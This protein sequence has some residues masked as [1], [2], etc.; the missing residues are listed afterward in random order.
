MSVIQR[1]P[2]LLARATAAGALM[3][4]AALP[5]AVATTA[6]ASTTPPTLSSAY[7]VGGAVASQ[8][9][10][11]AT[12][13]GT[14]ITLQQSTASTAAVTLPAG[15]II[16]GASIPPGDYLTSSVVVPA[17][18][19]TPPGAPITGTL[20][21]AATVSTLESVT[22]NA[23]TL[24]IFG[25]GA[26]GTFYVAGSGFA[27]NGSTITVTTSASG[28]TLTGTE[29]SDSLASVAYTSSS[30]TTAG[31]ASLTWADG[32]GTST[33]LATAFQVNSAPVVTSMSP[34]TLLAGQQ[35][36]VTLTG[37]NFSTPN[38]LVLTSTVDG[39]TLTVGTITPVSST[40]F[41]AVV[42]ATNPVGPSTAT[43]G[44]YTATVTNTDGGTSTS[45]AV[46]T[47]TAFGFTSASPSFIPVTGT[48]ATYTVTLSGTNLGTSGALLMATGATYASGT[49]VTGAWQLVTTSVTSSAITATFVAPSTATTGL[50]SF[51]WIN[52]T[53]QIATFDGAIGVGESSTAPGNA[54]TVTAV[55]PTGTILNIGSAATLVV[56][57]TNFVPVTS[58]TTAAFKVGGTT[59]ASGL[60][61]ASFT[62]VSTTTA[63][64][65]ITTVTSSMIAGTQDL[66]VTTA[67]GSATFA[68]ALTIGGPVI[69]SASPS[70]LGIGWSGTITLTGSGFTANDTVTVTG[71]TGGTPLYVSATTLKIPVTT[72]TGT[73]TLQVVDSTT[74]T[75]TSPVFTITAGTAPTVTGVGYSTSGTSGVGQ[76]ATAV[77][78]VITGAGYL[79][80]AT[81]TFPQAGAVG[82][83]ASVTSVSSTTILANV[84][85][86]SGT[87][88]GNYQV[89]VTNTNGGYV[90]SAA[91][92]AAVDLIVVAGPGTM[93]A[94]PSTSVPQ[95]A[96][97]NL[98]LSPGAAGQFET[99]A[100]ATSSNVLLTVGTLVL[101]ADGTLTVPV[102]TAAMTG[103]YTIGVTLTVANP[104]G[105]TSSINLSISPAPTVTGT[106]Y[107]PTFSSNVQMAITGTGFQTGMTATS[108][109]ADYTV[110][111]GQVNPAVAPSTVST[112]ILVV[113]TT[114]SA[115]SGTS[116]NVTFTNP[117]GSTVTFA[118]NGGPAPTPTPTKVLKATRV[119]GTAVAGRTVILRIVGT[120]F[121]GR[122]TVRSNAGGTRAIVIRDNGRVL[123]VRVTVNA[124]VRKGTH[125]FTII[126]KNGMR[127]SVHYNQR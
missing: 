101:N 107:V 112:A 53:G 35:A 40:S 106:Y 92:T 124:N 81:V 119:I 95:G 79:P 32:N 25:A 85:V 31:F 93:S 125:V 8:G 75:T 7:T 62:A 99:G 126:L 58:G 45:V 114:S 56:T 9:A 29:V 96:T 39:T 103:G 88:P 52:S 38:G 70:V 115:T 10:L 42:T 50:L 76:G 37:S 26:S 127:T 48:A 90:T 77:P 30:T 118:L 34:A 67:A 49:D 4:A 33:P 19:S 5:M 78:V 68:N 60:S 102:T 21:A 105:G 17:S 12:V 89:T 108:S 1:I 110:V 24:P 120:G 44:T 20:A 61:C 87:A 54:P 36:T 71:A 113:S 2:R 86:S 122:P 22:A 15:T 63:T 121:Y 55:S 117:D 100:V 94:S 41:T 14:T 83:S 98:T 23:P 51:K 47:V 43:A 91:A 97:T 65:V 84:T 13:T 18:T 66:V 28:M 11:Q 57:G 80:G 123:T 109:N 64:C 59:G 74:P 116:S 73:V 16:V 6:G 69:T 27:A 82:I 46:L 3:A 104:D 111:L 72:V